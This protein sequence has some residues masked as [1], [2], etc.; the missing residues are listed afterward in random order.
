M[1]WVC[2]NPGKATVQDE[3]TCACVPA[4]VPQRYEYRSGGFLQAFLAA[5]GTG[6]DWVVSVPQG[7]TIGVRPGS[8]WVQVW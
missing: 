5:S 4:M 2:P 7:A 8:K 6:T 3:I 1:S